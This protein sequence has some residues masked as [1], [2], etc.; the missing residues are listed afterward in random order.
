[1]TRRSLGVLVAVLEVGCARLGEY[2]SLAIGG[3]GLGLISYQD[4]PDGT[5]KV[6]HCEDVPCTKATLSTLDL[7]FRNE[8]GNQLEVGADTSIA[9]GIDSRGLI[10]YEGK[11]LSVAHCEDVACTRATVTIVDGRRSRIYSNALVIGRDGLGLISYRFDYGPV[12]M[13]HCEDV[14]CTRATLIALGDDPGT[15]RLG[16]SASIAIGVDGLA[17]MAYNNSDLGILRVAHCEDIACTKASFSTI[18]DGPHVLG[19]G[20]PVGAY[21]HVAIGIDGL[22]LISYYDEHVGNLRLAHCADVPCTRADVI[23]IVDRGGPKGRVG[24]DSSLAI[25]RDGLGLVGYRGSTSSFVDRDLK[26]A[27]CQDV[28]CRSAIVSTLD[29]QPNVDLGEYASLA[30]GADGLGLISYMNGGG[31]GFGAGSLRVAHCQD[32]G[33]TRA[34]VSVLDA[35]SHP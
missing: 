31:S 32:A 34:T 18:D 3:D 30:I 8:Q 35:T 5:L 24:V 15:A 16:G 23:S 2:T 11:G 17:L 12:L 20:G 7:P 28:P 10:S 1:M 4:G 25:G 9:I 19:I 29:H 26:A 13:A 21:A 6:A 14:D 27:H 33:C 22:G